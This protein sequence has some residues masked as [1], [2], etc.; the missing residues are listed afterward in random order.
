M[1]G[2]TGGVVGI[3]VGE[4]LPALEGRMVSEAPGVVDVSGRGAPRV[5]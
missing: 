5:P 2:V 3:G 4:G 1:L